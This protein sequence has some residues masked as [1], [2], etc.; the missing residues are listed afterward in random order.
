MIL[1]EKGGVLLVEREHGMG[2]E[3]HLGVPVDVHHRQ[4]SPEVTGRDDYAAALHAVALA[5]AAHYHVGRTDEH[6]VLPHCVWRAVYAERNLPTGAQ[7]HHV[8]VEHESVLSLR[9]SKTVAYGYV[10]VVV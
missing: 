7:D 1:T 5:Y 4:Y 3:R 6:V 2:L 9:T 10:A 8:E